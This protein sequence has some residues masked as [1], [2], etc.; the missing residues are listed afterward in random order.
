MKTKYL[1]TKPQNNDIGP[2]AA[3]VAAKPTNQ[4]GKTPIVEKAKPA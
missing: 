1:L 3:I 2:P 4:L